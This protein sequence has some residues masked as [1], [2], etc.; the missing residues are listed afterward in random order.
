MK[1]FAFEDTAGFSKAT[2]FWFSICLIMKYPKTKINVK[3]TITA[4]IN[5]PIDW[6]IGPLGNK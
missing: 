1:K 6:V 2:G 4:T 3:G 5:V